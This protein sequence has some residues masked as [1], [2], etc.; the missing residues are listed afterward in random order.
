MCKYG[1]IW[2][3]KNELLLLCNDLIPY[4]EE[5]L[6]GC[7]LYVDKIY[8]YRTVNVNDRES[9]YLWHFD[10]NPSEVVKNIIYLNQVTD[11]NSPF[12]YLTDNNGKGVLGECTR[13]GT[14]YWKDPK[15]NSRVDNLVNDYIARGTHRSNKLTGPMFTGCSFNNNAIHRANPIKKG[16]RDVVNIRVIPAD[17]P[18]PEYI[19]KSWTTSFESSGIVNRDPQLSWLISPLPS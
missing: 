19:D 5:T 16:Y 10:N 12:E 6:Y 1:N 13:R 17:T 7:Y 2:E 18:P 8:I 9:S 14:E 3:F 15:N 11:E 4:L